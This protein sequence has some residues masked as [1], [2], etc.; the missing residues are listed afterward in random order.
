MINKTTLASFAVG[1]LIT[2]T[3]FLGY[4]LYALNKSVSAYVSIQSQ[5]HSTL[6]EVVQ[7]INKAANPPQATPVANT[8]K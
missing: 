4:D 7:F 6:A 2:I 8:A 5:D 1:S 3:A